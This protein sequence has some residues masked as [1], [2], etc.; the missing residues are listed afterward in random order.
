MVPSEHCVP[1]R[2][3]LTRVAEGFS[4]HI[5]RGRVAR[6]SVSSLVD[7]EAKL[8]TKLELD[9]SFA[10]ADGFLILFREMIPGHL[11]VLTV[12]HL[13]EGV[14]GPKSKVQDAST[15]FQLK[16]FLEIF[17]SGVKD[18]LESDNGYR[19][20]DILSTRETS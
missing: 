20:G 19:K 3:I 16:L 12:T 5:A 4:G 8:L 7:D 2:W 14:D 10:I 6:T 13:E 17:G 11:D 1:I 9:Q 15:K 18:Q